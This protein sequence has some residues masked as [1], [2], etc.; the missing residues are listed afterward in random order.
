MADLRF[1]IRF[2]FPGLER[3]RQVGEHI[4]RL[5]S[6]LWELV[7][8]QRLAEVSSRGIE[9]SV[10]RVGHAA[11]LTEEELRE[12]AEALRMLIRGRGEAEAIGRIGF[13]MAN[14]E[15]A[16]R[17]STFALITLSQLIQDMPYGL[18]AVANNI[19]LL[20][21]QM[22]FLSGAARAAGTSMGALLLGSFRGPA[23]LMLLVSTASALMVSFGDRLLRLFGIV[24][25][26]KGDI[27]DLRQSFRE[28]LRGVGLGEGPIEALERVRGAVGSVRKEVE[29]DLRQ[30]AAAIVQLRLEAA[31]EVR[32]PVLGGPERGALVG[33]DQLTEARLLADRQRRDA[34]ESLRVQRDVLEAR[35]AEL[36]AVEQELE[37]EIK[38][39]RTLEAARRILEETIPLHERVRYLTEQ[40]VRDGVRGFER[41]LAQLAARVQLVQ[42]EAAAQVRRLELASRIAEVNAKLRD[43]EDASYRALAH[44]AALQERRLKLEQSVL[45]LQAELEAM[46]RSDLSAVRSRVFLMQQELEALQRIEQLEFEIDRIRRGAADDLEAER[47]ALEAALDIEKKRM[48]LRLLQ[49]SFGEEVG[50]LLELDRLERLLDLER[51]RIDLL[52]LF[53]A[54]RDAGL[55]KVAREREVL[56]LIRSIEEKRLELERLTTA[57]HFRQVFALKT[58]EARY[59][60]ALSKLKDLLDRAAALSARTPEEIEA[61]ILRRVQESGL[62]GLEWLE[63]WN[64]AQEEASRRMEHSAAMLERAIQVGLIDQGFRLAEVMGEVVSG[65]ADMNDVLREMT[66]SVG[67]M[68][69]QLIRQIVMMRIQMRLLAAESQAAAAAAAGG[70][71]AAAG[72]SAG[73]AA[74]GGLLGGLLGGGLGTL[75]GV[76]LGAF[77]LSGL[78]SRRGG[79]KDAAAPVEPWYDPLFFSPYPRRPVEQRIVIEVQGKTRVDLDELI[80]SIE[81][82]K[83]VRL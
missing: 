36:L 21:Q 5:T 13:Q 6:R 65:A 10:R 45:D 79:R 39:I 69:L 73:G 14:V 63:E 33:V 43:H 77:F 49:Q 38:R 70:R 59:D 54:G 34:V 37:S 32:G 52:T 80:W 17:Q 76:A 47:R 26:G 64:R 18:R 61:D 25:E 51:Q 82:R 35:R 19:E 27:D 20:I 78:L 29:A 66:S 50:R 8:G 28:L 68:I 7:R 40:E 74:A 16:A 60:A 75:I 44:A 57:E 81:K 41:Q 46:R 2:D 22:I 67:R 55:Q 31:R 11:D 56:D 23:G 24:K 3:I 71:A 58:L 53:Q 12:M 15:N 1:N 72:G 62:R 30:V 83:V 42:M 9:A 48:E 4:S